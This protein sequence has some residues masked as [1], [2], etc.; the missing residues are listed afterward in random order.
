[1]KYI[2]NTKQKGYA[3]LFAVV[4]ISVISIITIGLANSTFKQLILSSL[5]SDSQVSFFQADT[6]T[7]CALYSDNVEAMTSTTFSP[8]PCG[9]DLNG[10]DIHL[11]V[12]PISTGQ[13]GY[14]LVPQGIATDPCFDINVYKDTSTDPA[15]TTIKSRGYNSC[16]K[17]G[18]R[19]V[20]REIQVTY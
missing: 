4:I 5:A 18:P 3:I 8:W 6:A 9:V 13:D 1:M 2:K 19:T 12:G 17:N 7:E 11:L 20:E 15:G 16:N 14:S 10:G